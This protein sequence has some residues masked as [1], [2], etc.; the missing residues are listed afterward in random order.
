MAQLGDSQKVD[1][2]IAPPESMSIIGSNSIDTAGDLYVIDINTVSKPVNKRNKRV[3]DVVSSF[4]L[5]MIFPLVMW[6]QKNPFGFVANLFRVL[7]GMRSWIG[8]APAKD[9]NVHLPKINK[10]ILNPE[11]VLPAEQ[12]TEDVRRRLNLLYAKD[13]KIENDFNVMRRAFRNLGS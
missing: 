4:S 5:L 13:Y 7:F 1:Y 6:T 12:R 8:Y 11:E 3:F 2:K 9:L 10:G